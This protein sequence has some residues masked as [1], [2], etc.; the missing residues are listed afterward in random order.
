M[1]MDTHRLLGRGL[2]H[3]IPGRARFAFRCNDTAGRL[4]E[5]YTVGIEPVVH[6][7]GA[8]HPRRRYTVA[9]LNGAR[10]LPGPV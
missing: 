8:H 3:E 4:A 10:A 2:V 6:E 9:T 5:D 7:Q 1:I